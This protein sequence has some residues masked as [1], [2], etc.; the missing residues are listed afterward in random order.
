M[1]KCLIGIA[2]AFVA[3][4]ANAS[5]LYWQVTDDDYTSVEWSTA[6]VYLFEDSLADYPSLSG[7]SAVSNVGFVN[8]DN[9]YEQFD[10][11][12]QSVY[13]SPL[14]YVA[15]IGTLNGSSYSFFV[16]LS[17]SSGQRVGFSNIQTGVTSSSPYIYSD[18]ASLTTA[19][20]AVAS[21]TPW[22]ATSYGPVPEP[23]SAMLMLFG[24]AFLGLKR[25]NRRIA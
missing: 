19:L 7:V 16:E 13:P 3:T 21:V 18:T 17:N 1:K 6:K 15:D 4:V 23:T 8:T 10:V 20:S 12:T 14:G 5:Y 2:V 25:K 24:A 9:T 11:T 22:H